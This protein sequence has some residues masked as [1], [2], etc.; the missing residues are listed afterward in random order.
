MRVL[1]VDDHPLFREGLATLLDVRGIEVVGLATDGAE[2][3]RMARETGPDIVLMDLTM[4][5][6]S[7]L[8]ATRLI[9]DELPQTKVVVLTVSETAEDV[10]E[11]V[12]CGARGYLAKSSPASDFFALLE[13]VERG[14]P[15]LS[16]GLAM[17]IVQLL[18][19][20]RGA[21]TSPEAQLSPREE[22]VLRL[23][24]Q[25]RTNREVAHALD[26][27]ETTVKSHMTNI[28]GR[29]HLHNRAQAVAYAHEH[30][31]TNRQ[32]DS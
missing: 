27:S 16:P 2:A 18:A 17:K 6:M 26:V 13:A 4:P 20:Q 11:A 32:A 1:V 25:G 28:L 15:A 24:A 12:R 30:G 3:V 19:G 5:G 14:D 7:G 9:A 23:V 10:L 29:L 31:L 22:Q 8:E 21:T